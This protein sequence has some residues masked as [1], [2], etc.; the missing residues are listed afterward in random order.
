VDNVEVEV[1]EAVEESVPVLVDELVTVV[2][3]LVVGR[4]VLLLVVVVVVLVTLEN[5]AISVPGPSITT[6][7]TADVALSTIIP[8]DVVDQPE[9]MYP[10]SGVAENVSTLS[11]LNHPELWFTKPTPG[12]LESMVK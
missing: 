12:G 2:E 6:L 8:V 5:C 4:V 7:V 9:K 10:C 3:L 11:L 1:L